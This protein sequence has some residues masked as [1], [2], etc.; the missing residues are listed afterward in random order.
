M[1][2]SSTAVSDTV[3]VEADH[4]EEFA[5]RVFEVLG[6]SAEHASLMAEHI[7]WAHVHRHPWLGGRKIMQYGT[8]IKTGV[9]AAVGNA[10]VVSESDAFVLLD[11]GDTFSQ[12]AGVDAM[13]RTI[14]K[15]REVGAAIAVLRN[16]TSAGALGYFAMQAANER[17]IGMALNNGPPLMPPSG[18]TTRVIGNQAFAIASPA[19]V[20]DPLLLDM[21]LSAITLVGIHKYEDNGEE[22]PEGLALDAAA[23]PTTDPA[24]AL[25]GML[26]PM[27]GHR[28]YGLAVMWEVLTGV[29]SGAPRFLSDVTMPDVFDRPQA[30][31]M[32]FMA[33][34]PEISMPYD[35]FVARVDRL[36]DRIHAS[37]PAP[38]VQRVFVPGERSAE[39][40]R[41]QVHNGIPMSVSL[42][43]ELQAFGAE[44]GVSW[45]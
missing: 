26:L 6:M 33:I 40:G 29:L 4:L 38:G 14:E 8:R 7:T 19:G 16:T 18:G 31:S 15:A 9:T 20:H 12:I 28:G 1:T 2:D 22:L 37:P 41:Q 17:M 27:G 25:A 39:L 23:N 30:V 11:A 44:L 3:I 13:R 32:F 10:T 45:S 21:A 36:I 35:E 5:A 24:V 43:Q 34:D 42:A